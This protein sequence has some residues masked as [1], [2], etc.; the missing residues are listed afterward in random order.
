M[1]TPLSVN[2]ACALSTDSTLTILRPVKI[3]KH[4]TAFELMC[5]LEGVEPV[6][7][8]DCGKVHDGDWKDFIVLDTRKYIEDYRKDFTDFIVTAVKYENKQE[9][10]DVMRDLNIKA[11]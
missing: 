2:A 5:H 6:V 9:A 11:N 10:V 7:C 8:P 4:F 1:K 3:G